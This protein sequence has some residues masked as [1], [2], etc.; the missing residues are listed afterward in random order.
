[1]AEFTKGPWKVNRE[2]GPDT[3]QDFMIALSSGSKVVPESRICK[4]C[5]KP[6]Q[7]LKGMPRT[8]VTCGEECSRLR[9]STMGKRNR[10]RHAVA[11]RVAKRIGVSGDV[12]ARIRAANEAER[13]EKHISK[14]SMRKG[15]TTAQIPRP[16]LFL[17][18]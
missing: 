6:F 18:N 9:H 1:M 4:H 17:G 11:A 12:I 5:H 14:M 7:F 15:Q 10:K 8:Q 3:E 13:H 16:T 2:G